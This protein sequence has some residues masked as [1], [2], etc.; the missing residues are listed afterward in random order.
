MEEASPSDQG[1]TP[2]EEAAWRGLAQSGLG[3]EEHKQRGFERGNWA[4]TFRP[5]FS[6][7]QVFSYGVSVPTI[8]NILLGDLLRVPNVRHV[9][10]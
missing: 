8:G 6:E 9:R 4:K 5:T 7:L 3:R 2:W 1:V 10:A